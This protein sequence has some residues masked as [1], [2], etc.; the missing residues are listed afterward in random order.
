MTEAEF[1]RRF[2]LDHDELVAGGKSILEGAGELGQLLFQAGGGL[3]DLLEVQ[4][5]L[6]RELESL[7]KPSGTRPRIHAGLAELKEA[8]AVVRE[9]SLPSSEWVEHETAY[10]RAAEQLEAVEGR[11]ESARAEK[12]RLERIA[13]ALPVL[14]RRRRCQQEWESLG[15]VALLPEDF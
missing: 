5:N 1:S 15:P 4:R 13:D 6:D 12:R 8:R 9:G 7:F 3:K 2:A 10:R 11:L 14:A